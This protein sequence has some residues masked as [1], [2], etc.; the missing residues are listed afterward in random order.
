VE[1][2]DISACMEGPAAGTSMRERNLSNLKGMLREKETYVLFNNLN[3]VND[4]LAFR[5]LVEG[6]RW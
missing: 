5:L 2:L 6:R 4:A 3:M 1:S